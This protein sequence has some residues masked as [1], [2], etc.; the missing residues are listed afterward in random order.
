MGL[1]EALELSD[2]LA[3]ATERQVGLDPVLEGG[4]AKLLEASE[5]GLQR[6]LEPEV[7]EGRPAPERQRLRQLL[8]G[9][10]RVAC[11]SGLADELAEAVEVELAGL[12]VQ[13]ITRRAGD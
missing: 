4:E 13:L 5:L 1:R 11:R 3:V 6:G 2:R 8:G 10:G 12:D 7:V 9:G